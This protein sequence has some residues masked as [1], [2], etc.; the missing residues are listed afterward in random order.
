M[1]I[2]ITDCISKQYLQDFFNFVL[3]G[4]KSFKGRIGFKVLCRRGDTLLL[5]SDTM[6]LT[7]LSR[8]LYA[9]EAVKP[10]WSIFPHAWEDI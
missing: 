2:L 6:R 1:R 5:A 3:H 9:D 4:A 10:D 8:N 7:D